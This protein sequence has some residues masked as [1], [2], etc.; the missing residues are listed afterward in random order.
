MKIVN[1]SN[2]SKW[3]KNLYA[4]IL[5]GADVRYFQINKANETIRLIAPLS[6]TSTFHYGAKNLTNILSTPDVAQLIHFMI[7]C[8]QIN[9]KIK[10]K[11]QYK[12]L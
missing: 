8:G 2:I 12:S 4:K 6:N 3:E 1:D 9:R 11:R 5:W 10:S 7:D